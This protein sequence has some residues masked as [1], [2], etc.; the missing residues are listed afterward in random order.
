MNY[1]PFVWSEHIQVTSEPIIVS[2][3]VVEKPFVAPS[4]FGLL[5]DLTFKERR[6][7]DAA[8]KLIFANLILRYYYICLGSM[9]TNDTRCTLE[10]K[11]RIAM[12]K[13][14]FNK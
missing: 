10:I 4:F 5:G 11:S 12:A 9:L 14:A 13:E 1:L 7:W 6:V 8:L 2:A 3:T